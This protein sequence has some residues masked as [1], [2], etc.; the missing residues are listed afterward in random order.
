MELAEA[1]AGLRSLSGIE[2][3]RALTSEERESRA[4]WR[5]RL[6]DEKPT[7]ESLR[8][9]HRRTIAAAI[10]RTSAR[11]ADATVYLESEYLYTTGLWDARRA[12]AD[13]HGPPEPRRSFSRAVVS[14]LC[15]DGARR[16]CRRDP[17]G[18]L[19]RQRTG[20]AMASK[21]E[22]DGPASTI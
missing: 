17:L 16:L 12:D 11:S 15:R 14:F 6:A 10:S 5:E 18:Y 19:G 8:R 4:R 22:R 7:A 2:A 21:P 9:D 1:S 13:W 20:C 3:G